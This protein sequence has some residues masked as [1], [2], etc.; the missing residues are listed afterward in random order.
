MGMKLLETQF[1]QIFR[2]FGLPFL[3]LLFNVY[4]SIYLFAVIRLTPILHEELILMSILGTMS[5]N[6][7]I[8]L[9]V[10]G[11][12][13]GQVNRASEICL[14]RLVQKQDGRV[15]GNKRKKQIRKKQ[16]KACMPLAIRFGDNFLDRSTPF[17]MI[18]FSLQQVVNLLLMFK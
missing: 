12:I 2:H 8:L 6:T 13:S 11:T 3:L 1:N 14:W 7:G 4:F 18:S 10:I 9:L 16:Y 15:S 17:V 5:V